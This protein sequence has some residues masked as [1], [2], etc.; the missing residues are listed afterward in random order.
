MDIQKG[1]SYV[2][3]RTENWR[4]VE[5]IGER[6]DQGRSTGTKKLFPLSSQCMSD[7]FLLSPTGQRGHKMVWIPQAQDQCK[8]HF[9]LMCAHSENDWSKF[10]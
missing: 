5:E 3:R 7:M 4:E 2:N 10:M 8:H 1:N 9:P 6:E